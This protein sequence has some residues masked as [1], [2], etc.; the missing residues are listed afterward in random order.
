[1]LYHMVMARKEVLVQLEDDLVKALD[2]IAKERGTNRSELLRTA[3]RVIVTADDEAKADAELIAAYTAV[4]QDPQE[5]EAMLR[6][7]L[8]VWP[9]Y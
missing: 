8:E 5:T 6:I 1:M 9:D 3:A 2:R 7:A 4:P